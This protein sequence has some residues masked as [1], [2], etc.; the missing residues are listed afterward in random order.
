M[1][2][3]ILPLPHPAATPFG[4]CSQHSES[5]GLHVDL[6]RAVVVVSLFPCE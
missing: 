4:F 5:C 2:M 6:S 1:C 3:Y